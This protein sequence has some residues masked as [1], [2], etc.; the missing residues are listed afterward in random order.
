[1]L[2]LCL[3]RVLPMSLSLKVF[4][5]PVSCLVGKLEEWWVP[6]TFHEQLLSFTSLVAMDLLWF[7]LR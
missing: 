5:K 4:L 1:M 3:S 6:L 7:W 2:H